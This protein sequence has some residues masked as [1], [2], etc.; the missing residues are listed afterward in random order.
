MAHS[1][2][3]IKSDSVVIGKR[4]WV[5]KIP[6]TTDPCSPS[7]SSGTVSVNPE[8]NI[9]WQMAEHVHKRAEEH[10]EEE[11]SPS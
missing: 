8:S 2:Q 3:G 4:S 7:L 9:T 1:S 10:G 5:I 6:G 11:E